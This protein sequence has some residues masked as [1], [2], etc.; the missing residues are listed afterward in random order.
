MTFI[1]LVWAVLWFALPAY[2][3]WTGGDWRLAIAVFGLTFIGLAVGRESTLWDIRTD[4]YI[5]TKAPDAT[6]KKRWRIGV[7]ETPEPRPEE[8]VRWIAPGRA[9]RGRAG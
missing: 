8:G 6:G 2:I 7:R 3:L 1:A 5:L 4:G 9:G